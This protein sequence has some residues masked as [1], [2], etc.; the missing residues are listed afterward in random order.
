[1]LTL[2]RKGWDVAGLDYAFIAACRAGWKLKREDLWTKIYIKHTSKPVFENLCDP[3]LDIGCFYTMHS[4]EEE[5]YINQAVRF[6]KTRGTLLMYA[7][8]KTDDSQTRLGIANFSYLEKYFY[9]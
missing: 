7:F 5:S 9:W 6:L 3:V 1:M 4:K 2:A 8:L